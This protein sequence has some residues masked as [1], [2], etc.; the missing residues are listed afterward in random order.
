MGK[1][2]L[3]TTRAPFWIIVL[4]LAAQFVLDALWN[5]VVFPHR[6]LRPLSYA[7][8]GLLNVTFWANIIMLLTVVGGAIFILGH[9]KP[10]DVAGA[11]LK[12]RRPTDPTIFTDEEHGCETPMMRLFAQR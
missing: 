6:W 12:R 7:T 9:L 4:T 1:T 5:L 10:R 2:L 11:A 3:E 8:D